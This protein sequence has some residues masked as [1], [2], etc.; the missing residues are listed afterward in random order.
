M[1]HVI[2]VAGG[3][4]QR[5]ASAVPKQ[6]LPLG[7]RPILMRTIERFAAFD[8]AMDIIVVLPQSQ[9]DYWQRLC[10]EHRFGIGHRTTAGGATRYESVSNGL[11]LVDGEGLVG[12]HDGVRPLVSLPTLE[13]CYAM[14]ATHGNAIPAC[15]SVDSVR[16]LKPDGSNTAADRTCVKLVQTPQVFDVK[17]IKQA[18]QLGYRPTF[19]DDA[20]VAEAA[21]IGINLTEGNRENIKITTPVDLLLAEAILNEGENRPE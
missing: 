1:N 2:I 16:M 6:F 15:D 17:L 13:R 14:A 10:H 7:G 4:G 18:Y 8:P 19:T 12:I 3:S 20:S 21:G 11:A 9:T 5:M